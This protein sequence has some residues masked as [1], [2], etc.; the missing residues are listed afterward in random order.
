M[1]LDLETPINLARSKQ[2]EKHSAQLLDTLRLE[3]PVQDE[4]TKF[5]HATAVAARLGVQPYP[6]YGVS[7]YRDGK[8]LKQLASRL[9]YKPLANGHHDIS[10]E[11]NM[12]KK[13]GLIVDAYVQGPLV[14]CKVVIDDA[15][16]I[17]RILS[18]EDDELGLSV[19]YDAMCVPVGPQV[20]NDA[21]GIAGI[22][23][24]DYAYQIHQLNPRPNH[25]AVVPLGRGGHILKIIDEADTVQHDP[26][27]STAKDKSQQLQ[28]KKMPQALMDEDKLKAFEDRM[29]KIEDGL[30]ALKDMPG[31]YDAMEKNMKSMSDAIQSTSEVL[32]SLRIAV[33]GQERKLKPEVEEVSKIEAAAGTGPNS[34][35]HLRDEA[36]GVDAEQVGEATALW[37]KHKDEF[38]AAGLDFDATPDTLRE[39]LLKGHDLTISDS[40]TGAERSATLRHMYDVYARMAEQVKPEA[41]Q[42]AAQ[43]LFDSMTTT[44]ESP[45]EEA[46][47][48]QKLAD[49]MEFDGVKVN[50]KRHAD[51]SVSY[52]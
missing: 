13:V 6:E 24:Q 19:G 39:T 47:E 41:K 29:G 18:K 2:A 21:D 14:I 38:I 35:P 49:S 30:E 20:W 5:L 17:R 48:E 4:D 32:K 50:I 11:M 36:P 45:K 34:V 12:D 27:K 52:F 8:F 37:L 22:A 10:P 7:H 9:R 1:P 33:D 26:S 43:K 31:M 42:S 44:V 16:L 15:A 51:G 28:E 40:I 25:L 3:K 46:G 23:G